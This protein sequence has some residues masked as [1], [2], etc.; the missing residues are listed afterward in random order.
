MNLIG[1]RDNFVWKGHDA[2]PMRGGDVR[3]QSGFQ[4]LCIVQLYPPAACTSLTLHSE[5]Q[6]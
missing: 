1:D 3:F 4:P 6:L 5:W 2:L